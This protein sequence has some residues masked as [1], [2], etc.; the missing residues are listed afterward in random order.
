M[1]TSWTRPVCPKIDLSFDSCDGNVIQSAVSRFV[2]GLFLFGVLLADRGF[3]FGTG[4][5][6]D[7]YI[8]IIVCDLDE[9]KTRIYSN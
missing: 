7:L 3:K 4:E 9:F 1:N 5:K 2:I 6:V 8:Y